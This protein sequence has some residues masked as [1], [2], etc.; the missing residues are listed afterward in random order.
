MYGLAG[1]SARLLAA[2]MSG[3]L[4]AGNFPPLDIGALAWVA[5]V[6]V[7]LA[8]DSARNW[9]AGLLAGVMGSVYAV[10]YLYWIPLIPGFP[11]PIHALL[12][13]YIA[14]FYGFFGYALRLIRARTLAPLTLVA[15]ALWVGLEFIRVNAG[16]LGVPGGLLGHTQY[17]NIALIQIASLTSAYGISFLI[18]LVN[19]GIADVILWL[20]KKDGTQPRLGARSITAVVAI[21]PLAVGLVYLWGTYQLNNDYNDAGVRM[22][23]AVV[24]ANIPQKIKWDKRYRKDILARYRELTQIAAGNRPDLIVLPESA[25]PIYLRAGAAD[26]HPVSRLAKEIGVMLVVGS[27]STSKFPAGEVT[28]RELKNS[29]FL[30]NDNGEVVSRYDKQRLLPFV[31]YVPQAGRVPWPAWLVQKG[32]GYTPGWDV[33]LFELSGV[34]FGVVICWEAL[35][36]NP[37]REIVRRG[38]WFMLNLSNEAWFDGSQASRQFLAMTVFRAVEHRVWLLRAANTGIS[39]AID[40]RGVIRSRVTDDSG[41]ELGVSGVLAITIPV[42]PAGTFYTRYGDVFAF[43]CVAIAFSMMLFALIAKLGSRGLRLRSVLG[44]TGTLGTTEPSPAR[45]DHGAVDRR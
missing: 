32:G 34:P 31:E 23:V 30:V 42:A 27:A 25:L 6:P 36:P 40:P 4:L 13:F 38:A 11:A 24:Q 10:L 18:V 35:F 2:V 43:T 12:I 5:L 7:L 45:T 33:A 44:R 29:A 22:K 3:F 39:A 19:A 9:Q 16:F 8:A 1:W 26:R 20:L 28:R 41:Q 37:F 17:E 21:G 14:A 15:P